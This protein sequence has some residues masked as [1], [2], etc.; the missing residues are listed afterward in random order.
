MPSV[1]AGNRVRLRSAVSCPLASGSSSLTLFIPYVDLAL[2][3]GL[4]ATLGLTRSAKS[5]AT[6]VAEDA[7]GGF[8]TAQQCAVRRCGVIDRSSLAREVN[9]AG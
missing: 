7:A 3:N 5:S 8:S 2:R 6:N 9:P 4:M 1:P